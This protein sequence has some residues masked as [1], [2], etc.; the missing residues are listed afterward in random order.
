[1]AAR[2]PCALTYVLVAPP[3]VSVTVTVYSMFEAA[4]MKT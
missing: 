2:L 1:M 4:P 3:N